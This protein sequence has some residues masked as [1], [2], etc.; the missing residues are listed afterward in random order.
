MSINAVGW[1]CIWITLILSGWI[2]WVTYVKRYSYH[3]VGHSINP[4]WKSPLMYYSFRCPDHGRV[5]A[6]ARGYDEVLVCPLCEDEYQKKYKKWS[7]P[8][9]IEKY[10]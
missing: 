5:I 6:Y 8:D 4:D 2:L 9:Y 3:K 7:K 10:Q 1:L